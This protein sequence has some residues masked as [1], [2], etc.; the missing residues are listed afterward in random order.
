MG[1]T[2]G[3]Y[4]FKEEKSN[5]T[6]DWVES[7]LAKQH[8]LVVITALGVS[9]TGVQP[10]IQVEGVDHAVICDAASVPYRTRYN[11]AR[12]AYY[13]GYYPYVSRHHW[14]HHWNRWMQVNSRVVAVV[15]SADGTVRARAT[16]DDITELRMRV[17]EPSLTPSA[18]KTI[19]RVGFSDSMSAA[20][21]QG[22]T[23]SVDVLADE[24]LLVIGTDSSPNY[25]L[26][27]VAF[28]S[29][30]SKQTLLDI[31]PYSDGTSVRMKLWRMKAN[32]TALLT[33]TNCNA[34]RAVYR[35]MP[36]I[37]EGI[38]TPPAIGETLAYFEMQGEMDACG[39]IAWPKWWPGLYH[40]LRNDLS[41]GFR[42]MWIREDVEADVDSLGRT[43]DVRTRVIAQLGIPAANVGSVGSDAL[44]FE[45]LAEADAR[46][47]A[48]DNQW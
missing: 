14:Y 30:P 19:Q 47:I 17:F 11:L 1:V 38:I 36:N 42:K 15:P 12:Q 7:T 35:L 13:Y 34:G 44:I 27:D 22:A 18:N 2:W 24:L 40:T 10:E 37:E 5:N 6:G 3:D 20:K 29:G 31:V 4:T 48:Q 28:T 9:A 46:I 33:F 16:G 39:Q 43:T 32:G 21:V 45:N 25:Q 26:A 8:G 23:A 41:A